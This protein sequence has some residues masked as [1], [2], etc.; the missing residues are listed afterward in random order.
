MRVKKILNIVNMGIEFLLLLPVYFIGIGL[1][2]L[3]KSLFSQE[4]ERSGWL[5]CQELRKG[6]KYYEEMM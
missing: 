3:L 6:I 1:S 5:D 2:K 4:E